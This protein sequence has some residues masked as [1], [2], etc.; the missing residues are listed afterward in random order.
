MSLFE[1]D[2]QDQ[3]DPRLFSDHV[4]GREDRWVVSGYYNPSDRNNDMISSWL[5]GLDANDE[6]Q[7]LDQIA[8]QSD[9]AN[10]FS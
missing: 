4:G 10:S 3:F 6:P 5:V 7:V 2:Y 9:S 8:I 1:F